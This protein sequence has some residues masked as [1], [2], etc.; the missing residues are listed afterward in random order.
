MESVSAAV[1]AIV[2]ADLLAELLA[3]LPP[4]EAHDERNEINKIVRRETR[5][6]RKFL[7]E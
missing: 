5:F 2:I 4:I 1:D 3:S 6:I 7:R